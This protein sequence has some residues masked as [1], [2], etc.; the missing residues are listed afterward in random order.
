MGHTSSSCARRRIE[1]DSIPSRPATSSATSRIRSLERPEGCACDRLAI[2]TVYCTLYTSRLGKGAPVA[3]KLVWLSFA[4]QAAFIAS[5]IVA[6]ALEPRYSHLEE[7]VSALAAR[8]AA[9]PWIVTAGLIALGIA[10][11]AIAA[12]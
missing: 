10:I 6:G 12:G 9:H 11:G 4:G 1:R 7:G 3:R 8:N 5:W 2:C